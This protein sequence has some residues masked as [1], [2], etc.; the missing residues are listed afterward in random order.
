MNAD[1]PSTMRRR[2]LAIASLSA[3]LLP[4]CQFMLSRFIEPPRR[5]HKR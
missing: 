1:L 2:A 4:G 3:T 5:P